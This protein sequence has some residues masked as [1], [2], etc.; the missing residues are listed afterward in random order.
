VAAAVVLAVAVLVKLLVLRRA[1]VAQASSIAIAV[2]PFQ[3]TSSD[4]D[5]EYLQYA[6]PEEVANA[7][8]SAPSLSV[9]PTVITRKYAGA[10]VDLAAAARELRVSKIVTGDYLKI[11]EQLQATMEVTEVDSNR[12]IC[13]ETV[14]TPAVDMIQMRA[15]V[16]QRIRLSLLPALG[17]STA[18]DTR[19]RPHREMAY[20]S[21]L[22]SIPFSSDPIPNG[23][24]ISLLESSVQ[25]D[26]TFAP[27]WEALGRRYNYAAEFANGGK[28]MMDL[29]DAALEK[30][31]ALD[32]TRIVAAGELITHR[33]ERRD[34]A[35]ALADARALVEANPNSAHAHYV[36]GYVYRYAGTLE[37]SAEEC[38]AAATKD[39][40]NY[41][42]RTCAWTFTELGQGE[43]AMNFIGLA[44][45][46]DWATYA[47]LTVLMGQ[48]KLSEAREAVQKISANPNHFRD[49][50]SACLQPERPPELDHL[51]GYSEALVK[52]PIDPEILYYQGAI[53][54]FCGKQAVGKRLLSAAIAGNYCA[55]TA[56]R[57][58][59]LVANLRTSEEYEQLLQAASE[60]QQ[61][62]GLQSN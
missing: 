22:R 43:R 61:R 58:D 10:E 39:P 32:P 57:N 52:L 9:R 20:D 51:V 4:K 15:D 49:L 59:P 38:E 8:T 33:A 16:V 29:S 19:T 54:T 30:A 35:R 42:F 55:K 34:L 41:N 13:H 21:Y 24:G 62:V 1:P 17:I 23:Q 25:G 18:P 50:L 27:A 44:A 60:C 7:L 46:S 28:A 26:P 12:V 5:L 31:L 11:N 37:L 48:G 40:G 56:L 6:I 2:L 47:T 45:G 3:N 53:L 14:K 36:L